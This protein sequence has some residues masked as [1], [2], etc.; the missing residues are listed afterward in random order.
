MA[1][2]R[3]AVVADLIG[4]AP[5]KIAGSPISSADC[6]IPGAHELLISRGCFNIAP[7][8]YSMPMPSGMRPVMP[9]SSVTIWLLKP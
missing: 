9:S 3:M 8:V 6:A 4:A 1:A 2:I 7:E 5:S